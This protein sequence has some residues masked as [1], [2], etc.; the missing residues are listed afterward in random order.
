MLR[1]QIGAAL[2][3]AGLLVAGCAGNEPS[4]PGVADLGTPTASASAPNKNVPKDPKARAVAYSKCMRANGVESFPDPKADGSIQLHA[5]PGN[6]MDPNDPTFAA[7]DK[8]CK[9]LMPPPEVDRDKIKAANL[10]Y[11][12]CM[13]ENGIKSFPDPKAD[14]SLQIENKMGGELDPTNPKYQAAEKA[15]AKFQADGGGETNVE[16]GN[17]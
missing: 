6:G 3:L 7:A 16:Q 2:V 9:Y 5:E 10:K 14:G 13:R 11:S 17:G 4:G 12:K 1:K 8:A 15:C